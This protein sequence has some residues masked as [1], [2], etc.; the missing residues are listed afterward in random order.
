LCYGG[1]LLLFHKVLFHENDCC[2]RAEEMIKIYKFA[3]AYYRK[4][5]IIKR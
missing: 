5:D 2:I 1:S 4:Y 3:L